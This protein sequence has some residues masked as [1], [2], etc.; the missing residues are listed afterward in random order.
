MGTFADLMAL[1]MC[2]FV[3]LLSFSEMDA[4]KFK[5]LA[6]SMAQAFGVQQRLEVVDS[7]KGTSVIAQEFSPGR[8]EPTP[9]NEIFQS[10]DDLTELSLKVECQEEYEV[11][12][13]TEAQEAGAQVRDD[14]AS[15]EAAQQA[16]QQQLAEMARKTQEDAAEIA[17]SLA[18]QIA[19]GEVE[20]EA[21]GRKIIIRI[22]EQGS[23]ASGSAELQDDYVDVLANVRKVIASK[24]GDIAIQ[25]HTDS[26]PIRSSRFRSNWDL[27]AA[28]AAS[29]ANELLYGDLINPSR[30]RVSGFADGQP[31]APNTTAAG[32]ARN[33]R[34]EVVIQ[35]GLDEDLQ[36][37]L[38]VLQEKAPEAY[39]KLESEYKFNLKPSEIF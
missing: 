24:P 15:L 29:V 31:L 21:R 14:S 3:L 16:L 17:R 4:M 18:P 25:G 23:F 1:L 39:K 30:V 22:R 32:R 28:R 8:P 11:E 7:P 6:G 37:E 13:G 33:R 34:V 38:K 19:R 2:F 27:S 9:I 35:Q 5:R 12:A 26:L 10:T 36:E 20:V